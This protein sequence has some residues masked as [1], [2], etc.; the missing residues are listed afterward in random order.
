MEKTKKKPVKDK[1]NE[2]AEIDSVTKEQEFLRKK[3][4]NLMK[5]NKLHQ[6]RKIVKGQ[7][8]SRPWGQ[9]A[10]AKVFCFPVIFFLMKF[11]LLL[12]VRLYY[13]YFTYI[14]WQPS[15]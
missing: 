12:T 11:F 1:K 13:L 14:G 9:E 5:K 8:D 4:T 10:Q 7:D 15:Y 3:V 2:D 6:V